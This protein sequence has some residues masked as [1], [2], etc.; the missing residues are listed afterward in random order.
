MFGSNFVGICGVVSLSMSSKSRRF[1]ASWLMMREL[2]NRIWLSLVSLV[3]R[4][5]L[6]VMA[7]FLTLR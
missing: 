5:G 4:R 3:E 1:I 7:A 2:R 6:L